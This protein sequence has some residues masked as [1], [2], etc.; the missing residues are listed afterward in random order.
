MYLSS[1]V[2]LLVEICKLVFCVFMVFVEAKFRHTLLRAR[3]GGCGL[4]VARAVVRRARPGWWPTRACAPRSP[5]GCATSLRDEIVGK[6][7]ETI[8]LGVPALCY[9]VQ[10]NLIFVAATN[11]SAAAAQA[12]AGRLRRWISDTL[13]TDPT[14]CRR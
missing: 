6:S 3:G 8:Q 4:R 11:L 9:V 14:L 12:P 2:V 1:V 13:P 10:N 5:C 7:R